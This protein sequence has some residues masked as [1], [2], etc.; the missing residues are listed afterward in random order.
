MN[1]AHHYVEGF[2]NEIPISHVTTGKK[3]LELQLI[4]SSHDLQILFIDE[5][6]HDIA[7]AMSSSRVDSVLG[8]NILSYWAGW[9]DL[10]I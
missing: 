4:G 2:S 9:R 3:K 6:N 10:N 7:I 5:E 8:I 1:F